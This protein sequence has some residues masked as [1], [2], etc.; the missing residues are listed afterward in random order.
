MKNG[1][2]P[3]PTGISADAFQTMNW[4]NHDS[5]D[6]TANDDADFLIDYITEILCLFWSGEL[7]IAT[8]KEG[9]L[10]PVP[11]R[12]DLANPNKWTP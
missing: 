12:G 1:K 3:G 6:E 10:S 2:S 8:W 4:R 9:T 7:D 11:K 5:D